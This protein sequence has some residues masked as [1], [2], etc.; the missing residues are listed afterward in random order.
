M[1][2]YLRQ[3][4]TQLFLTSLL[5]LL[6]AG[7]S[8]QVGDF[9]NDLSVGV[10]GGY[11]LNS[12]AFVPKVPQGMKGGVNF[13]L[14]ARYV[15]E[16]YFNTICAVQM[17]VN[18]AQAGWKEK[19]LSINDEPCISTETG[20]PLRYERTISY[21]QVPLL[22]HLG[23]GRE[24]SGGK[25]FLNLGPQFGVALSES[26]NTNFTT[27]DAF[28]TE[29]SRVSSVIAQDTMA[30][31]HKFDYGIAAGIG[32]EYSIPKVGHFLLE[33]RYY[34]GLG[35]IYKDSKADYF[36]RSNNNSIIFKLTYLFDIIRTRN[37]Q[38]R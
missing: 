11:Q 5:L 24:V 29:P 15:C 6:S 23:W 22:A 10:N 32:M 25:F 18:Y 35:N 16:K 27:D 30:V 33:A 4:V 37:C 12:I 19:I 20:E 31:Q 2:S 26:T 34:Y 9:R 36:S 3:S 8:A 14:S 21:I 28:D 38:R 1:T 13:G 17:E 7:M